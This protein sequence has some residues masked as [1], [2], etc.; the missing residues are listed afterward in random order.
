VP[1]AASTIAAQ[2]F[3]LL[4][5]SPISSFADDSEK[6]QSA[7]EQYPVAL[8]ACLEQ[9]DWSFASVYVQ[10]PA[11]VLGATDAVDPRLPH[12]FAVPGNCLRLRE[13]GDRW[14][15]WRQDAQFLRASDPAPLD[16][17]YTARV[18]NEVR[19]P[20]TFHDA[21]AAE[22]ARRLAPRWLGTAA[23]VEALRTEAVRLMKLALR[24]DARTASEERYDGDE[25]QGDWACEAV[26]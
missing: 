12:T 11:A 6:A 8:D 26:R 9:G 21:V 10:L 2:A 23:K 7:A 18:E 19:L 1:I 20:A 24:A 3:R 25:D 15:R 17:R 22:L 4:E 16:V 5:L 14:T 13:V